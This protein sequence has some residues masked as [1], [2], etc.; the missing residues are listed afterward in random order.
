M[1]NQKVTKWR[2][3]LHL[4]CVI[5]VV[6][7]LKTH[8]SFDYSFILLRFINIYL[9]NDLYS[10]SFFPCTK[11]A[12]SETFFFVLIEVNPKQLF[13]FTGINANVF[14][15]IFFELYRSIIAFLIPIS[16]NNHLKPPNRVRNRLR[17]TSNYMALKACVINHLVPRYSLIYQNQ[18]V[19]NYSCY[20]YVNKK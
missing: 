11:C 6:L 7:V 5:A 16:Y 18:K 9:D 14:A 12:P 19:V 4:P 1:Y 2:L 10:L 8:M 20:F 13:S 15:S 17:A 3:I